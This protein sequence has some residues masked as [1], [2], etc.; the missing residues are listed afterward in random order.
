M[1][2]SQ[3]KEI[4]QKE[5]GYLTREDSRDILATPNVKWCTAFYGTDV[6]NNIGFMCHFDLPCS[7]KSLPQ[8]FDV[9][10][11]Y[12]P[13]NRKIVCY[14]DG[15]YWLTYSFFTRKRILKYIKQFNLNGWNIQPTNS[16]YNVQLFPLKF[17]IGKGIAYRFKHNETT[18][19]SMKAQIRTRGRT[20]KNSVFRCSAR[21]SEE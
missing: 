12:I 3:V 18:D 9:L 14:I 1:G 10:E 11:E 6:N 13:K 16:P 21:L 4:L 5:W 2:C 17:C 20:F 15:G 19:Y 7:T 8:L